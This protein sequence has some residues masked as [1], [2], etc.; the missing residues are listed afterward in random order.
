[1][2]LFILLNL[3][4]S[5]L[6]QT[7]SNVKYGTIGSQCELGTNSTRKCKMFL[8]CVNNHCKTSHIS[9]VCKNDQECYLNSLNEAGI[10][11]VEN[12]CIKKRY[13]C[14]SCSVNE[15][16]RFIIFF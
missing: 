12:R 4:L 5:V 9:S 3:I 13:N 8:T 11:C 2:I 7:C 6:L 14:Q 16:V 1:M 10:K 15:H